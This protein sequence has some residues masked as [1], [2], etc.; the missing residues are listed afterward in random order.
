M[1]KRVAALIMVLFVMLSLTGCFGGG[2][3]GGFKTFNVIGRV[4]S[5][6]TGLGISGATVS[7]NGVNGNTNPE[8]YYELKRV[9]IS[10]NVV[11]IRASQYGY[12]DKF[13]ELYVS[14]GRTYTQNFQLVPKSSG[15]VGS[16]TVEGWIDYW[17]SES[18]GQSL[19][20]SVSSYRAWSE[21]D[22][23]R[24]PDSVI[25]ELTG[26]VRTDSVSTLMTDTHAQEY[27]IRDI[28]NRVIVKVPE[29]ESLDAFMAKMRESPVVKRVVPNCFVYAAAVPNDPYYASYQMPWLAAMNLPAA[30]EESRGSQ[31]IVIAVVDTGLRYD[32]VDFDYFTIIDGWDYVDEDDYPFDEC[33]EPADPI[34]ASHGTHVAGTIGAYTNNYTGVAGVN[35]SVSLMPIRVL[36]AGGSGTIADLASGI[37]WA[38]DNGA[39]IINLSLGMRPTESWHWEALDELEQQIKYAYSRGVIVAAASGNDGGSSLC[40][41]AAYPEV[42]AVG[43]SDNPSY[44]LTEAYF[45]TGG[46]G[47]D[48]I[49]PGVGVWSTNYNS[50]TGK[51][52]YQPAEGTSMA[53]PHVVGAIGLMLARNPA[54]GPERVRTILRETAIRPGNGQVWDMWQGYGFINAYA[55]V[56]H[57]TL[58]KAKLMVLDE[59]LEPVSSA[60]APGSNRKFTISNVP[61]AGRLYVFGWLDVNDSGTLDSGDY[62]GRVEIST[63]GSGVVDAS[64]RLQIHSMWSASIQEFIESGLKAMEIK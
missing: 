37:K 21:P 51:L 4:T 7:V 8:G 28:I 63:L 3:S 53:C 6:A 39:D 57:A 52:D 31:S 64:F 17:Y 29:G 20:H 45:S 62:T 34:I 12:E 60:V 48:V 33:I 50:S 13:E 14:A 5:D 19:S 56:T 9:P 1:S 41:P 35:W 47:L 44:P 43:A 18:Y 22:M 42:I 40:Y 30:W 10:D 23:M 24:E 61:E 58:D 46:D 11:T 54:L 2:G 16:V 49:A 38:V 59:Q 36:G 32:H 25:V 26:D 15:G 27:E 55:A